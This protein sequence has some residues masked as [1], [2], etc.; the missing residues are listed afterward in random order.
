[1]RTNPSGVE[2]SLHLGERGAQ[3]VRLCAHVQAHVVA[4]GLDE[5]DLPRPQHQHAIPLLHQHARGFAHRRRD[6]QQVRELP[7]EPARTAG[8][9]AARAFQRRV[10]PLRAERFQ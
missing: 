2:P 7:L 10:N 3:Q 1:M 8:E 4:E 9:E 5:I 6:A